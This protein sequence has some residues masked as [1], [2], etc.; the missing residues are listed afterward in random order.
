[1]IAIEHLQALTQAWRPR[2]VRAPLTVWW[3][4][5][6]ADISALN[7]KTASWR[8]C[9]EGETLLAGMIDTDHVGIVRDTSMLSDLAARLQALSNEHKEQAEQ[10]GSKH[11]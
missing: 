9:S 11:G 3:S 10:E 5:R 4:T 7:D 1:L 8:A 2:K 6:D